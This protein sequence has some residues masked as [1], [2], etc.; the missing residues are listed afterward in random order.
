L[1]VLYNTASDW[2]R[3]NPCKKWRVTHC[4]DLPGSIFVTTHQTTSQTHE[5]G[6]QEA[7]GIVLGWVQSRSHR[8][9]QE[10]A[11]IWEEFV[12]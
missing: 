10:L 5:G 3:E 1:G 8:R 4:E 9:V 12:D 6:Q 2:N 11:G 7:R